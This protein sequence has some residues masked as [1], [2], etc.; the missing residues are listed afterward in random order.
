M[1]TDDE[2][3]DFS[4]EE[5]DTCEDEGKGEEEDGEKAKKKNLVREILDQMKD[6]E[7]PQEKKLQFMEAAMKDIKCKSEM[8]EDDME[9][10]SGEEYSTEDEMDVSDEEMEDN[11]V[12]EFGDLGE[13]ESM[14][15]AEELKDNEEGNDDEIGQ[16]Q[17]V[18]KDQNAIDGNEELDSE[19]TIARSNPGKEDIYGRTLDNDGKDAL[20]SSYVPPAKRLAMACTDD[21]KRKFKLER[22]RKQLKGIFNRCCGLLLSPTRN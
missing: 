20:A 14:E 10:T 6:V 5:S 4:T 17:V 7:G 16:S 13:E 2:H 9:E 21:A 12:G 22:L 18:G 3:D 19:E 15:E 1:F 11:D 8:G